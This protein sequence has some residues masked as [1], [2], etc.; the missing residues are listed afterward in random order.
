MTKEI[1]NRMMKTLLEKPNDEL[2]PRRGKEQFTDEYHDTLGGPFSSSSQGA[3]DAAALLSSSPPTASSTTD[4]N[5]SNDAP[6]YPSAPPRDL[7]WH[8]I[9]MALHSL[10][11]ISS[12]WDIK[13]A[14]ILRFPLLCPI[15]IPW[16][17]SSSKTTHITRS[18]LLA[19]AVDLDARNSRRVSFST[20]IREDGDTDDAHHAR[21]YSV[22]YVDWDGEWWRI[23]ASC[24]AVVDKWFC[25]F[26]ECRRCWGGKLISVV[27]APEKVKGEKGWQ[28]AQHRTRPKSMVGASKDEGGLDELEGIAQEGCGRGEGEDNVFNHDNDDKGGDLNPLIPGMP[29]DG[30]ARPNASPALP[31]GLG[32]DHSTHQ[33]P[34]ELQEA[35]REEVEVEEESTLPLPSELG[36]VAKEKRVRTPAQANGEK[37]LSSR[38]RSALALSSISAGGGSAKTSEEEPWL[39]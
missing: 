28:D 29:N 27:D 15:T 30:D 20:L 37:N 7:S 38:P 10:S 22:K 25:V 34:S 14:H 1:D 23:P 36:I 2:A 31:R 9:P 8:G 18:R 26:V 24:G 13:L 5:T 6:F 16:A 35:R 33:E 21:C 3:I 4:D 32:N 19:S 11:A 39:R 12:P 17:N